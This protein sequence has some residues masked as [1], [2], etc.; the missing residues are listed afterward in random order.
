MK[1]EPK[2]STSK[3]VESKGPPKPKSTI[4][5]ELIGDQAKDYSGCEPDE[6][7]EFTFSVKVRKVTDS[8]GSEYAMM[9]GD[10]KDKQRHLIIEG[11]ITSSDEKEPKDFKSDPDYVDEGTA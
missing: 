3:V 2:P 6:T 1:P 9:D 5:V 11:E 8:L 10:S 4:R 7:K